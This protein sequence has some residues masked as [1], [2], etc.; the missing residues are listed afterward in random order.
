[1][2]LEA[3]LQRRWYGRPGWLLILTPLEWLYRLLSA[4]RRFAYRRAWF[5]VW[6]APVPVIVVGNI[7]VGG[8]GKTPIVIALCDALQRNG[9]KPG[10]ISRGYG[11]HPPATPFAVNESSDV[12]ESGDEPLL[13]ARRSA[14]PVVIAPRRAAAAQYLLAHEGCDIIICDDGLQHYALARDIELVVIDAARGFGN[15]HCLP[16]GPLRESL[17]RLRSVD[18]LLLNRAA[19][20]SM[21]H[22][23]LDADLAGAQYD[24]HLTP[25]TVVHLVSN[26]ELPVA[27]WI[28]QYPRV[29]AVAGIGNPQR[30]FATLRQLGCEPIEHAFADHHRFVAHDFDFHDALAVLMTEKDA[31]KC[32]A[33]AGENFWYLRVEAT[34]PDSLLAAITAKLRAR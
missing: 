22:L 13:L 27:E 11:A 2:N 16:V 23:S 34:L 3:S 24:F 26:R 10:I 8:T 1:M 12:A 18:A 14:C 19:S 17:R 6:R 25:T 20:A 4:L 21:Q 28:D 9:F 15:G 7:A 32:L 31:V 5:S 33:L 30:F 29:H